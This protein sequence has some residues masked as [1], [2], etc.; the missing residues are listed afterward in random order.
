MAPQ[1]EP[2]DGRLDLC[3]GGTAGRLHLLYLM[4]RFLKGT[5]AKSKLITIGRTQRITVKAIEGVLPAHADG[6]TLCTEGH[7]LKVELLPRQL[8]ILC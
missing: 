4:T 7:E 8:E 5:Q 1:A 2:D 3:I 6:E